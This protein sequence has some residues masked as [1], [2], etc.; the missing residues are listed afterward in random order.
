M[1][2]IRII[3]AGRAG[4]SFAGAWQAV[5]HQV[6]LL[7]RGA[8]VASAS[9]GAD[10]VLIATPDRT[11]ARVAAAIEPGD[12]VVVH[13][14]G[15]TGLAPLATHPHHGSIH[16]LM[17]LPDAQIGAVRLQSGGWFAVAGH[18]IT[19]ELVEVL[20]GKHFV[21]ADE[22]RSKYHATA[23]IAANHL[24]ALLGQ[25]ERL[26]AEVGVPFD[27]FLDMA[28]GSLDDVRANGAANALTG[29]AARGDSETL[30]EHRLALA[31]P[32]LALYQALVVAAEALAADT[33]TLDR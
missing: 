27:A 13:C 11:I 22:D 23:A 17:A 25:V 14:S 12:A 18:A 26:A 8:S 19:Q 30:D 28:Q 7:D 5:G 3:G 16:P 10:V 33:T 24:V 6:E 2:S 15:A 9:T 21:V 29:P 1:T 4:K 20:G 32:E 31:G